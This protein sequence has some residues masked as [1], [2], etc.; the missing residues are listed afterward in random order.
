MITFKTTS[1]TLI[2][3]GVND[4]SDVEDTE[5]ASKNDEEMICKVG[6]GKYSFIIKN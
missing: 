3:E 1:K 4:I 6:S 2:S 5:T